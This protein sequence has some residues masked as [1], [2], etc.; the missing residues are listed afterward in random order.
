M[1][2]PSERLSGDQKGKV[3]PVVPSIGC[4]SRELIGRTQSSTLLPALAAVKATSLP[5]GE[6]TGG[7]A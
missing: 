6:T 2:N 5:S 4:A 1:K 3:A 7:P